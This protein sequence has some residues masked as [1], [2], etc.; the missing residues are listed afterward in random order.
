M[1]FV[2]PYRWEILLTIFIGILKFAIPL[3]IPILIK[4][5]IDDIIGAPDLTDS[6]KLRS[7]FI[8]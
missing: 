3:F 5:V 4:I 2:K 8:G 7:S 1:R 6:E